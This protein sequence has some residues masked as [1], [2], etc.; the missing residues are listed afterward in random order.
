MSY[1]NIVI[2]KLINLTDPNQYLIKLAYDD[3]KLFFVRLN[4]LPFFFFSFFPL[5]RYKNKI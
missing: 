5:F 3:H 4:L 1:L 2:F